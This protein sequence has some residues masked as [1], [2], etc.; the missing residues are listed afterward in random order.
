MA[1]VLVLSE[2]GQFKAFP[3]ASRRTNRI[4]F[5]RVVRQN[6]SDSVSHSPWFSYDGHPQSCRIGVSGRLLLHPKDVMELAFA[7]ASA[8]VALVVQTAAQTIGEKSGN[9]SWD[10]AKSV[11]ERIRSRFAGDREAEGTLAAIENH[12]EEEGN[13]ESLQRMLAA[14]MLRDQ[15]FRDELIEMTEKAGRTSSGGAA[16]QA[17]MIKN[18]NVFNEKVQISGDWNS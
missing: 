5:G 7:A 17:S 10:A 3:L 14:Y 12:P 6:F 4:S 15:Q 1:P 16:I 13:Q 11:V 8:A 9:A 18:A 2:K